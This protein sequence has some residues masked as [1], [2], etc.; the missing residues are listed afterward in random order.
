MIY[1]FSNFIVDDS[2]KEAYDFFKT[3]S[4]KNNQQVKI[5]L[6]SES[7]YGKT[8]LLRSLEKDI[9]KQNNK[10]AIYVSVEKLVSDIVNKEDINKY[11]DVNILIIDDFQF[12]DNHIEIQKK[13]FNIIDQCTSKGNSVIISSDV[14]IDKFKSI[15]EQLN[16]YLND[17]KIIKI[18]KPNKKIKELY[19]TN[20]IKEYDLNLDKESINLLLNI[21]NLRD[22]DFILCRL[23]EYKNELTLELLKN[24]INEYEN[25]IY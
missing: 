6:Y 21:K 16:E 1:D 11:N 12:I 18:D 3:F 17:S 25:G 8:H 5:Y 4:I 14:S 19:L 10:K 9:N 15:N 20:K 13:I 7:S 23:K 24:L 22:I 2:N